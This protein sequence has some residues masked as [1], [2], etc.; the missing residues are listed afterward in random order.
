MCLARI[1]RRVPSAEFC[2]T[3][4]VE[5][6]QIRLH[7]TGG[8]GSAKANCLWTGDAGDEVWGVIYEIDPADKLSLDKAEGL[9]A[10][11]DEEIIAIHTDS[12]VVMAQ[13]YIANPAYIDDSLA[14]LSW[15]MKYIITG[16]ADWQLPA[17]YIERLR[18]FA[19]CE[20]RSIPRLNAFAEIMAEHFRRYNCGGRRGTSLFS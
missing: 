3:G 20:D 2:C 1:R 17:A 13:V 4:R 9:G 10:G 12:G 5:K 11:Y 16:A 6:R 19:T 14:P 8:D 15:Y 18:Q 7:K